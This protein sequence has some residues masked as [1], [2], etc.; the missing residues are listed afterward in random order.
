MQQWDYLVS[1]AIL[2]SISIS[3]FICHGVAPHIPESDEALAQHPFALFAVQTV[4]TP[5]ISTNCSLLTRQKMQGAA[6]SYLSLVWDAVNS[7]LSSTDPVLSGN[8]IF[9]LVSQ[10][11]Y[12][13]NM[14]K[15]IVSVNTRWDVN[16]GYPFW[17]LPEAAETRDHR[18]LF[19]EPAVHRILHQLLVHSDSGHCI[20]TYEIHNDPNDP[21]RFIQ[22]HSIFHNIVEKVA[23]ALSWVTF[24]SFIVGVVD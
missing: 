14:S 23:F 2:I 20:T 15:N 13:P 6:F 24:F 1:K 3:A 16:Y 10:P 19:L 11:N 18:T 12:I 7:L 22:S 5:S 21:S 9:A 8:F 4:S 17:H